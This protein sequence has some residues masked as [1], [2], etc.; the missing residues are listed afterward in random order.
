LNLNF[1]LTV[2]ALLNVTKD[3]R[4]AM[5]NTKLMAI[6][7][8]DFSGAFNSVDFDI[9]LGTLQSANVSAPVVNWFK[10]YLFGRQQCVRVDD[11]SSHWVYLPSGVPQGEVLSPLLFSIFINK[12]S[13]VISSSYH[14]Y[15]QGSCFCLRIVYRNAHS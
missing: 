11:E 2:I 7:L 6:I 14:L 13:A 15:E 12:I 8:L 5:N 9:F 1:E 4:Y 10:T 3:I